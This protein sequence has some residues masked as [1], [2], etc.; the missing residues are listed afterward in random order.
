MGISLVFQD[1]TPKISIEFGPR[2]GNRLMKL[3]IK[4]GE[5]RMAVKT[6]EQP[7]GFILRLFMINE[8]S[9]L[10]NM[11]LYRESTDAQTGVVKFQGR[12]SVL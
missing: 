5:I 9:C 2:Y 7:K 4:Y 10:F 6:P 3:K 11:H 8:S 1:K 12:Y